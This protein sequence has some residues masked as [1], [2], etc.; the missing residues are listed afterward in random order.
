MMEGNPR[1][2]ARSTRAFIARYFEQDAEIQCAYLN[3]IVTPPPPPPVGNARANRNTKGLDDAFS[4]GPVDETDEN[5]DY[6]ST[7]PMELIDTI[8]K[9][10]LAFKAN[11]AD[12]MPTNLVTGSMRDL[13]NIELIDKMR[14]LK[15]TIEL[16]YL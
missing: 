6:L 12:L 9:V 11:N 10:I 3:R 16:R 8:D 1:L 15:Q 5:L 7:T 14:E 13:L 4:S 2:V